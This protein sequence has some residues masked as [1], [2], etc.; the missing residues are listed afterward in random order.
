MK[1]GLSQVADVLAVSGFPQCG[2]EQAKTPAPPN[3]GG[4][5]V[6]ACPSE[7]TGWSVD[8]RSVQPGDLFFALHGP[9]FDGHAYVKAALDAGA[10]AAVVDRELDITDRLLQVGDTL[11]ALQSLASW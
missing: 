1:L 6:F 8:S 5:G 3:L 4:A 7:I 9:N 10:V 11:A 2:D